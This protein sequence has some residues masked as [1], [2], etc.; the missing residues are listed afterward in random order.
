MDRGDLH[1]WAVA[2]LGLV[3]NP[4]NLRKLGAYSFLNKREFKPLKF[5]S[6][7]SL[8]NFDAVKMKPLAMAW[9]Q[10]KHHLR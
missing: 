3:C 2:L 8:S 4:Q 5:Y 7:F 9:V 1:S 10:I 6:V